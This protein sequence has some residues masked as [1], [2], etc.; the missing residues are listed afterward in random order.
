[1]SLRSFVRF[2]VFSLLF[3]PQSR[4]GG[5][6]DFDNNPINY[7]AP[8][9]AVTAGSGTVVVNTG[10]VKTPLDNGFSIDSFSYTITPT[11]LT[12]LTVAWSPGVPA[13]TRAFTL[14]ANAPVVVTI[15]GNTD[16]TLS[17]GNFSTI[18][19]FDVE[20][21]LDGSSPIAFVADTPPPGPISWNMSSGP[22]PT[23]AGGH[24]LGEESLVTW[25]PISTADTLTVSS[26]YTVG[27]AAVPEPSSLT[28]CSIG[29]LCLLALYRRAGKKHEGGRC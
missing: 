8:Y 21:Y 9:V 20:G 12:P 18:N 26:T 25:T 29:A 22:Q 1:M 6:I 24:V 5:L 3:A 17:M 16:L 13:A 27:V 11:A 10:P 28:L 2:A 19:N 14:L 4:A 23:N 15:A 7:A